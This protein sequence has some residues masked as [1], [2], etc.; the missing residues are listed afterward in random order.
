LL[1]SF[2]KEDS[3]FSEEKEAK[4]LLFLHSR[5][6]AWPCLRRRWCGAAICPG[7]DVGLKNREGTRH[8][9]QWCCKTEQTPKVVEERAAIA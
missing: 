5:K 6:D 2:K 9:L 3:S 8:C 1:L 4:R 7:V